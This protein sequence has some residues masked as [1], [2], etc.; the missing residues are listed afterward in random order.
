MTTTTSDLYVR[1]SAGTGEVTFTRALHSEW[2]KF[3][4]LW[5]A[6]LVALVASLGMIGIGW[7]AAYFI[8]AEWAHLRPRQLARFDPTDTALNGYNLAQL[9]VGTLGVLLVTGEYTT[10][11]IRATMS[12]VPARQPVLWAKLTIY[13]AITL[14]LMMITS[15]AAFLGGQALLGSH[16]TNLGAHNVLRVV[17][18]TGLYL[19]LVGMLGVAFGALIRNTAGSLA[20]LLGVLLVLPAITDVLPATWQDHVVKYLPSEAGHAALTVA[21]DPTLLDPWTGMAVLTLY[22]LAALT[23]AATLLNRRDV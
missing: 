7:V 6:K 4:T 2:I 15:F 8:N 18:A 22:V 20:T 21:P 17:I 16:A 23:A 14:V 1:T 10:G 3:R 19:T 11:M 12:A 13:T 9:A 5:S